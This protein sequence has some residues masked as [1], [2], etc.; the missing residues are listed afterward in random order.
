MSKRRCDD[1]LRK[2]REDDLRGAELID[3]YAAWRKA[4][5]LLCLAEALQGAFV[6]GNLYTHAIDFLHPLIRPS[7]SV[8][9]SSRWLPH[10]PFSARRLAHTSYVKLPLFHLP[11][12]ILHPSRKWG[13]L[14][15]CLREGACLTRSSYSSEEAE[16]PPALTS[17]V[18][19]VH[20]NPRNPIR[21]LIH[22]LKWW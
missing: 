9:I 4:F 17:T 13:P 12:V 21:R 20:C 3:I 6:H 19:V 22:W 18:T 11:A 14:N 10:T 2:V 15:S 7:A 16:E 1:R 8:S 5:A